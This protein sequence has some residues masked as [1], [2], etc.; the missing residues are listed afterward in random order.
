M[1]AGP[2]TVTDA[3]I[4]AMLRHRASETDTALLGDIIRS[5]EATAQ[6]RTGLRWPA[7]QPFGGRWPR[8]VM[9]MAALVLMVA[10][11]VG[12]VAVGG[13][14]RP[15]PAPTPMPTYHNNGVILV[16]SGGLAQQITDIGGGVAAESVDLRP[17]E[18]LG[19]A[20]WSPDGMQLLYAAVGEGGHTAIWVDDMAT[21]RTRGIATC[22]G[23]GTCQAVWSPDG[24]LIAVAGD[25]QIT[26]WNPDGILVQTL[27]V[28]VPSIYALSWSP[29]GQHLA[30]PTDGWT[31]VPSEGSVLYTVSRDDSALRAIPGAADPGQAIVDVG[32]APDGAS[33]AYL[34]FDQ[35]STTQSPP[36][37]DLMKI[38]TDGGERSRIAS[39]GACF[40]IGF[41]PGGMAWSP[42]GTR[43]A[44]GKPGEGLFL[45]NADG[46][47][48][49]QVGNEGWQYPSWRPVP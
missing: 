1:T 17:R 15:G 41:S 9:L 24:T 4:E 45:V 47:G 26:L 5:V 49:H 44:I 14:L 27:R 16:M 28:N 33:I 8:S 43:I 3:Q 29:D 36:P 48:L 34:L 39:A 37:I 13:L 25:H 7:V 11:L 46:T 12:A 42:D 31:S 30:F 10:G 20:S 35:M 21:G 19:R 2:M 18:F 6:G 40:C 22:D 32:W 38:G 23:L